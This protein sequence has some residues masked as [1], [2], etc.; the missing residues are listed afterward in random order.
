MNDEATAAVID[1][2]AHWIPSKL[3][4]ALHARNIAVH[5]F[6]QATD[7]AQRLAM[8]DAAGVDGQLLSLPGL[9]GIDSLPAEQ[10]GDLVHIFNA[11]TQE[12]VARNPRR[13]QGLASVPLADQDAA[14]RELEWAM[15]NGMLGA[16]LP[17]DAFLS[18]PATSAW[19]P[20]ME[21][22]N[23]LGAHL[24][25]HPG[26]LPAEKRWTYDEPEGIDNKTLR[27]TGLNTQARISPSVMTLLHTDYL[28][29]FPNVT[30]QIANLGGTYPFV[31]DRLDTIRVR[32]GDFDRSGVDMTRIFFDTASF[33]RRSIELAAEVFSPRQIIYGTDCPVFDL[34]IPLKGVRDLSLG[35][36]AIRHILS[37]NALYGEGIFGRPAS[38]AN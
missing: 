29:A 24:F 14:C 25:I 22:A 12:L 8:L 21:C 31:L 30:I 13:F 19:S 36:S 33:S 3:L 17:N 5:R 18:L 15:A 37:G 11:L 1:W 28:A 20:L 4:E 7:I 23:D 2:H 26:P 34:E 27:Q 16:I 38:Q 32:D 10:S 35:E 9:F 6:G